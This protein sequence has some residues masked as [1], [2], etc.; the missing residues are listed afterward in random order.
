MLK[1]NSETNPLLSSI[2]ET[3]SLYEA[4]SIPDSTS[5]DDRQKRSKEIYL[6]TKEFFETYK[7]QLS[8]NDK[9]IILNSYS[10]VWKKI[11]CALDISNTDY[12]LKYTNF[13]FGKYLAYYEPWYPMLAGFNLK[14]IS[15]AKKTMKDYVFIDNDLSGADFSLAQLPYN[16][17][18]DCDFTKS[19]PKQTN[20]NQCHFTNCNFTEVNFSA[21][22]FE[23]TTFNN[24]LLFHVNFNRNV[25]TDKSDGSY[26]SSFVSNELILTD[27]YADNLHVASSCGRLNLAQTLLEKFP[28]LI[29]SQDKNGNT[30]LHLAAYYGQ[31]ELISFLLENGAKMEAVNHYEYVPFD[32]AV[33]FVS[34]NPKIP[35]PLRTFRT[36]VNLFINAGFNINGRDNVCHTNLGYLA[37][38]GCLE[39]IKILHEHGADINTKDKFGSTPLHYAAENRPWTDPYNEKDRELVTE[40]LVK[41]GANKEL[42]DNNNNTALNLAKTFDH[43]GLVK[44]LAPKPP[45]PLFLK[46]LCPQSSRLTIKTVAHSLWLSDKDWS[47]TEASKEAFRIWAEHHNLPFNLVDV[48]R[49]LSQ[50]YIMKCFTKQSEQNDETEPPIY[51]STRDVS[52]FVPVRKTGL[53]KGEEVKYTPL[54]M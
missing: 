38:E 40:W 12:A 17:F 37:I 16:S 20:F 6:K 26:V 54:N 18:V 49:K 27:C 9:F 24:C 14:N 43:P 8:P 52:F 23:T 31:T 51:V 46:R 15:F 29:H 36:I 3:F 45:Y 47:T 33:D 13:K 41:M 10:T 25:R 48:N 50:H 53:L 34:I 35:E 28:Y 44:L 7:D 5:F 39:P 4:T 19:N 2:L 11:G 22:F 42:K 32:L 21:T 1:K 30:P